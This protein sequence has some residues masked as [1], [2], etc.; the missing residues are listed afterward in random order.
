[1]E[2]CNNLILGGIVHRE[3]YSPN[4]ETSIS[5]ISLSPRIDPTP[6]QRCQAQPQV[7]T[8]HA[9]LF[10]TIAED[11]GAEDGIG[12]VVRAEND[13]DP[14]IGTYQNPDM[15]STAHDYN[16]YAPLKNQQ[17]SPQQLT[18]TSP[19]DALA[20]AC[21][22]RRLK[23]VKATAGLTKDDCAPDPSLSSSPR[24]Q[25]EGGLKLSDNDVL[26]GRGGLTNHHPGNVF[27]RRIVRGRRED[28]LR[29]SKRDKAG[30]AREIVESIR[31]LV[32][33][34]RFLKRD[35][36]NPGIWIEIGNRKAREKT[37][38]ALR[39]GAPELREELATTHPHHPASQDHKVAIS[40]SMS[41]NG[42]PSAGTDEGNR[43]R[44]QFS[45][46]Q[47]LVNPG[48]LFTATSITADEIEQATVATM[49]R[50]PRG[51]TVSSDS[52]GVSHG[53]GFY[54]Y[55][56]H[57]VHQ[58]GGTELAASRVSP[59]NTHVMTV[60]N[61]G[62]PASAPLVSPTPVTPSITETITAA[63]ILMSESVDIDMIPMPPELS[64]PQLYVQPKKRGRDEEATQEGTCDRDD[65]PSR[66]KARGPR[67]RIFKE[68]MMEFCQ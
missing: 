12:N 17:V 43:G 22:T 5:V 67:L 11:L 62:F 2:E 29:A 42:T 68:R 37:S 64:E 57:G 66:L 65:F 27:F 32:P 3:K 28:Y 6:P 18:P 1:M 25:D 53:A 16:N 26:C 63:G 44:Q 21:A 24:D 48:V 31:E 38:Q 23:K 58:H 59:T 61:G 30:V 50:R 33:S 54:V 46:G 55:Q 40:S 39:E 7:D 14:H 49:G 10:Q 60:N 47:S 8:A 9:R 56:T 19:L 36:S 20:Q 41:T 52:D 4:D 51:R 45:L 13:T 34:G 15:R 35:T